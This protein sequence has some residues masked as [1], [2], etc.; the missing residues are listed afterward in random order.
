MVP[1]HCI[2]RSQELKIDLKNENFKNLLLK[3]HKAQ[4][5][6]ILHVISSIGALPR[7]YN[8]GPPHKNGPAP[9]AN[10]FYIAIYKKIT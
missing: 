1:V 5:F 10:Q 7:L 3:N 8:L 9:G 6:N 2:S 4:S